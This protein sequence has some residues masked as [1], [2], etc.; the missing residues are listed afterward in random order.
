MKLL[1]D[2][3]FLSVLGGAAYWWTHQ[4]VPQ[5]PP[6]LPGPRP[7]LAMPAGPALIP[8]VENSL[9]VAKES[10]SVDVHLNGKQ[11]KERPLAANKPQLLGEPAVDV[12]G[13]RD[14]EPLPDERDIWNERLHDPRA[15]AAVV[16]LFILLYVLGTRALRKGPGGQ[17]FTHD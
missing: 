6:A 1:R 3:L 16:V 11:G 13:G 8:R 9:L 15:M 4:P 7:N 17:G 10:T 2:L 14:S 5:R 12:T